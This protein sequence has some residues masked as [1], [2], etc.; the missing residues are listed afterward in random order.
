MKKVKLLLFV[1][2]GWRTHEKA[3]A[4]VVKRANTARDLGDSFS[5]CLRKDRGR[6]ILIRILKQ[7]KKNGD[8]MFMRRIDAVQYS[9]PNV[10]IVVIGKV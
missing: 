6:A 5:P 3:C 10:L 8:H 4:G 2:R 9:A 1:S 7:F